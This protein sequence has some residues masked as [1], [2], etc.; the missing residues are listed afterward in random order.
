MECEYQLGKRGL[1]PNLGGATYQKNIDDKQQVNLL[2]N[3]HEISIKDI[4]MESF[5]WIMH[6]AD[7]FNSNLNISQK[8]GIP[9]EIINEAI[10]IFKKEGLLTD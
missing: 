3:N 4:H 9:L 1:M 2:E 8:S 6:L 7:G 5:N 10:S